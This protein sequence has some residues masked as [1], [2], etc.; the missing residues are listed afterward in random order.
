M[1]GV[2]IIMVCVAVVVG[3]FLFMGLSSFL[4]LYICVGV[5]AWVYFVLFMLLVFLL[6]F[7]VLI[8]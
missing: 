5:Y 1:S 3:A 8:I 7:D 2:V 4:H 6:L